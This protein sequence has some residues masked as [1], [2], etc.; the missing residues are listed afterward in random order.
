MNARCDDRAYRWSVSEE[1]R[2][3][4]SNPCLPFP[5]GKG[6]ALLG[7]NCVT[8]RLH[9][10]AMPRLSDTVEL[11]PW[12]AQDGGKV[13]PLFLVSLQNRPGQRGHYLRVAQ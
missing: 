8:N 9:S 12:V 10:S 4:R 2:S 7:C 5:L 6:R 3:S 1:Q 11:C 13:H